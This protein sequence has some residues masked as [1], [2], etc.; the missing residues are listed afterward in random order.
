MTG[1]TRA[2][3]LAIDG[4]SAGYGGTDVLHDLSLPR[5]GA[6]EVTALLGPNGSGKSTLLKALAGLEKGR[7]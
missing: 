7:A 2:P 5:L 1:A 3:A 6:V 4:I